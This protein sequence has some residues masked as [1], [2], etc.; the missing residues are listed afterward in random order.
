MEQRLPYSWHSFVS[1]TVHFTCKTHQKLKTWTKPSFECEFQ[2]GQDFTFTVSLLNPSKPTCPR[3][4]FTFS[5]HINVPSFQKSQTFIS[6][7]IYLLLPSQSLLSVHRVHSFKAESLSDASE[8]Q[9]FLET[10]EK[11]IYT[12][13]EFHFSTQQ[14]KLPFYCTKVKKNTQ[15][16]LQCDLQSASAI[17]NQSNGGSVWRNDHSKDQTPSKGSVGPTITR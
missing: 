11:N 4:A 7:Q 10:C 5:F 17:T 9:A 14:G 1:R 2:I 6:W 3:C 16:P 13:T 15:K 12:Y 8:H